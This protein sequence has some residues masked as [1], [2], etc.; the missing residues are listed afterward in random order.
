MNGVKAT[1]FNQSVVYI[2]HSDNG[3]GL[4]TNLTK[5]CYICKDTK[6]SKKNKIMLIH[7]V[8]KITNENKLKRKL[9]G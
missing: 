5:Y 8:E 1:L 7:N 2:I 9:Y 6:Q 4:R 3:T